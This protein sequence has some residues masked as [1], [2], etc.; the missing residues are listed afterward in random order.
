MN[1]RFLEFA[2]VAVTQCFVA[3]NMSALVFVGIKHVSGTFFSQ[4]G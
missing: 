4:R 3:V 2:L 1:A